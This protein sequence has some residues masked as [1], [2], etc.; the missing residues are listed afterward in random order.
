MFFLFRTI[1][2]II[3][4]DLF[5]YNWF[6]CSIVFIKRPA[7]F[8]ADLF[9]IS[10]GYIAVTACMHPATMFVKTLV[11]EELPPGNCAISV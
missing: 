1:R 3:D 8:Y 10:V 6:C 5:L 4:V 11:N 9:D 7:F 2:E